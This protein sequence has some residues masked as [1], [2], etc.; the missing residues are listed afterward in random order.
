M[1][2]TALLRVHI[3]AAQLFHRDFLVDHGLN[4]I[5]SRDK[6]LRDILHHKDKIADGGRI[7]GTAGTGT[8]DH[9]NL[10]DHPGR[11]RMP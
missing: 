5:R 4:H 9:R 2:H 6:H 1:G 11:F 3:R 10:R 7:A 8:E